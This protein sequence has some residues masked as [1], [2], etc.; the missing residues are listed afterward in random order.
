MFKLSCRNIWLNYYQ[1][2]EDATLKD[3]S[4]DL[5]NNGILGICGPSGSGKSSLLYAMAGLKNSFLEGEI[6]Y[7]DSNI[8]KMKENDLSQW[9]KTKLGFV[10]QKH[11][12]IQYLTVNENIQVASG[13]NSEYTEYFMNKLSL[14]DKRTKFPYELSG[15]ESQRVA[16]VRALANEPEII[17][18]DEPTAALDAKYT[19]LVMDAFKEKSKNCLII[20]VSH[21]KNVFEYF[22]YKI[23]LSEGKIIERYMC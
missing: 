5:P 10:F 21:D 9:R 4:L 8:L 1:N 3:I 12:L 19:R 22:D 20:L 23:E 6:L 2:R 14:Y 7:N 18:A 16:I 11:Y 13:E 15:G 17:F